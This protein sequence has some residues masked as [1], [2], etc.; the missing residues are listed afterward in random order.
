M[1]L[2]SVLYVYV[3]AVFFYTDNDLSPLNIVS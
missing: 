1:L 3:S 2:S